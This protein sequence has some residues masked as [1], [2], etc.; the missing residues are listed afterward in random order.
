MDM[1]R[2]QDVPRSRQGSFPEFFTFTLLINHVLDY[3]RDEFGI[4]SGCLTVFLSRSDPLKPKDERNLNSNGVCLEVSMFKFI[5]VLFCF[6][7]LTSFAKDP[8]DLSTPL[9]EKIV[10]HYDGSLLPNEIQVSIYFDNIQDC[11]GGDCYPE[12]RKY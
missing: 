1:T 2:L 4:G 5:P 6:L 7:S 8:V 11:R 10:G 12:D 3:N 9:V